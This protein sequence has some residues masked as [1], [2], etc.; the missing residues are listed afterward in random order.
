MT[1][2]SVAA[3][4]YANVA[5]LAEPSAGLGKAAGAAGAGGEAGNGSSFGAMLKDALNSVAASGHKSDVQ[6]QAMVAGKADMVD[7]VT[8]V[9]ETEVAVETM[10]AVRNK[11]IEAYQ[12]IMSMPI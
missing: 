3:N 8:A 6:T 1:I 7:V 9:S 12:S 10:V 5:R 4:A 11:V 2:P